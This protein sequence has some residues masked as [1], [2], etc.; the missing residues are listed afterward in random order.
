MLIILK[1]ISVDK[2]RR[3]EQPTELVDLSRIKKIDDILFPLIHE[4]VAKKRT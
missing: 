1:I 4:D 2:Q 3:S